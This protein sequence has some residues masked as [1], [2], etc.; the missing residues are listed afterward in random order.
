MAYVRAGFALRYPL[1]SRFLKER[2]VLR[3][4]RNRFNAWVFLLG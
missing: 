3:H 2:V 4:N 1:H